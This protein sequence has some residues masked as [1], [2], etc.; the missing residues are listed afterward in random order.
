MSQRDRQQ[1]AFTAKGRRPW[2]KGAAICLAL[3]GALIIA[4]GANARTPEPPGLFRVY[5]GKFQ[6]R[7]P[8]QAVE[9]QARKVTI[10]HGVLRSG[11]F[12]VN[13]PGGFSMEAVRDLQQEMG[14]RRFSWVG[15]AQDDP[16]SR[17][18]LGVSANTVAG[19]FSYRGRL[20]KLEPRANGSHVVSEVLAS[21]PAPALD[22]I[23]VADAGTDAMTGSDPVA[24]GDSGPVIYVLVASTPRI[25]AL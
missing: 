3:V 8:T 11:R 24:A 22:P 14:G 25:E 15:H 4:P 6:G 5:P 12:F 23:P 2:G 7:L 18:V 9:G 21:D 13:L 10:N 20:F 1:G 19:T 17:V 16:D